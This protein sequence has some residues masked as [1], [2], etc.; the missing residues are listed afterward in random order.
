MAEV[1]QEFTFQARLKY[2][3]FK[4]T[5]WLVETLM[6]LILLLVTELVKMPANLRYALLAL[7]VMRVIG[8]VWN[9]WHLARVF[10][11]NDR[12]TWF[13]FIGGVS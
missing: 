3:A 12:W 9:H 7:Q 8:E 4:R 1:W 5:V 13:P 2:L 11:A 10:N 6:L